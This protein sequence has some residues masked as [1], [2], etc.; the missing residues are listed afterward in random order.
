MTSES[1]QQV[2]SV[3]VPDFDAPVCRTTGKHAIRVEGHSPNSTIMTSETFQLIAR[4]LVPK[5]DS[6]VKR[7]C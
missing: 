6:V 4:N 2:T 3:L 7:F 5:I 1:S